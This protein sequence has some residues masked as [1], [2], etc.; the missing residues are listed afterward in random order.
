MAKHVL[1]MFMLSFV[2]V[3]VCGLVEWKEI[4]VG[5]YCLFMHVQWKRSNP[6]HQGTREI[7]RIVQ[8]VGILRFYFSK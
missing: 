2:F 3:R 7:C 6:K 1:S 4:C 8:D 5:F